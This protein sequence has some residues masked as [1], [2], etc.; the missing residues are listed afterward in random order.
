[1]SD[2]PVGVRF[3]TAGGWTAEV[4]WSDLAHTVECYWPT[5]ARQ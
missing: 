4:G 3:V 5:F 1:M 2:V